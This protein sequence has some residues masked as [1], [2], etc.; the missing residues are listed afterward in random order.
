MKTRKTTKVSKLKLMQQ[1]FEGSK[2]V[3]IESLEDTLDDIFYV[4][5]IVPSL[6]RAIVLGGMPTNCVMCMHGPYGGGK[7]ILAALL[8]QSFINAGGYAQYNDQE[9]TVSKPWFKDLGV[10]TSSLD[11]KRH[12]Y[13]EDMAEYIE[14]T[15]AKFKDMKN[16]EI[17]EP[18]AAMISVIDSTAKL[19]PKSEYKRLLKE[20]PDALD[21]GLERSRGRLFQAW[22]D[23][24]TPLIGE[25]KIVLCCI[26]QER[27][28]QQATKWEQDFKVKGVQGLLYDASVRIRVELSKKVFVEK[29][30]KKM[31]VGQKHRMSIYKNKVGY[32][33]EFGYFF[34]SNGKG[35]APIGYDL[36][37]TVIEEAID[38]SDLFEKAGAWYS[39]RGERYQ[40]KDNF[41]N[42]L[43]ENKKLLRILIKDL[44]KRQQPKNLEDD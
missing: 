29:A 38:N 42:A 11:Y 36:A 18:D 21:K 17:F 16:R 9:Y 37:Q 12:K 32:P 39:Y 41:V 34:I 8:C 3:N 35:D 40:G 25:E 31:V 28:K 5:T 30:K 23:H 7:S 24:M 13:F 14:E 2:K 10:D 6:N 27:E 1:E 33:H 15:V 44:N 4:P 43:R 26:A 22:L 20:G 19:I